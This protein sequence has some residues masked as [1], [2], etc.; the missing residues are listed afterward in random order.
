MGKMM[1]NK[2]R[3]RKKGSTKRER[4]EEIKKEGNREKLKGKARNNVCTKKY[5]IKQ[6]KQTK[7]CMEE[8]CKEGGKINWNCK[9]C[10]KRRVQKEGGKA[11]K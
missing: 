5:E 8:Q 6:I 1:K 10:K 3:E 7:E 2:K 9:E 11:T 4:E